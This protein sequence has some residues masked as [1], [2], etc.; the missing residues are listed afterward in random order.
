MLLC[1]QTGDILAPSER[2]VTNLVLAR[3]LRGDQDL[4]FPLDHLE[5]IV[6]RDGAGEACRV[7]HT[8]VPTDAHGACFG[9]FHYEL[10]GAVAIHLV[11]RLGERHIIEGYLALAPCSDLLDRWDIEHGRCI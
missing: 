7:A 1:N 5:A 3:I 4:T 11:N 10:H 2:A 9:L 8:E 6:L